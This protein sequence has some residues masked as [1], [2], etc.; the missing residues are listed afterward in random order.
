[1]EIRERMRV[2]YTPSGRAGEYA[3]HGYALNLYTTCPHGCVYCYNVCGNKY[4]SAERFFS[5]PKLRQDL[6]KKLERDLAD[7]GVLPEPIFLSFGSDPL[8]HG[9]AGQQHFWE[10]VELIHASGNRVRVLTKNPAPILQ[11]I[12]LIL[13]GDEI[14]TTLVFT[15]QRMCEF[16]EPNAPWSL[17]R[18]ERMKE[19]KQAK[20][21]GVKLWCSFEPVINARMTL[22]MASSAADWADV[23]KFGKL[24]HAGSIPYR[25]RFTLEPVDWRQ[26]ALDVISLMDKIGFR[27]Y[28]L[29]EDLRKE[30]EG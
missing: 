29:K 30:L 27:D 22:T 20:A 13:P 15:T 5:E 2:I 17:I 6:M 24:N 7:V 11:H 10:V 25:Q 12:H 4:G 26:F 9:N 19:I 3:D 1:M 16:W 23:M 18:H 8:P 28:V 21:E 14:G